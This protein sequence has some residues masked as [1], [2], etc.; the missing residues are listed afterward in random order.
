L[1][2]FFKVLYYLWF[3]RK[4]EYMF[5]ICIYLLLCV[6]GKYKQLTHVVLETDKSLSAVSKLESRRANVPFSCKW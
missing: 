2:V 1:A 5:Y 3:S 6:R 4:T